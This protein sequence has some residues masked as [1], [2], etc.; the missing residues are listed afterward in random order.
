MPSRTGGKDRE[1]I[2]SRQY[3]SEG[4]GLHARQPF[5]EGHGRRTSTCVYSMFLFHSGPAYSPISREHELEQ[6]PEA[7]PSGTQLYSDMARAQMD[8]QSSGD[9][10]HSTSASN[11]DRTQ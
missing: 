3:W 8:A 7:P 10:P 6:D 1:R 11:R 2:C 4:R 9:Q 5:V